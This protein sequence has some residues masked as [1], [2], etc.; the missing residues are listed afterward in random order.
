M[1]F[2]FFAKQKKVPKSSLPLRKVF[3]TSRRADIS[4]A[5]M[6]SMSVNALARQRAQQDDAMFDSD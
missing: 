6:S 3:G 5:A 1:R 4:D 2:F